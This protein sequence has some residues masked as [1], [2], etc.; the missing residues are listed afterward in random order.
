MFP[1]L[2]NI[3]YSFLLLSLFLFFCG[4]NHVLQSEDEAKLLANYMKLWVAIRRTATLEHI[5]SEDKLDMAP[6]TEDRT[7]PLLGKV[8]LPP[9]MIQ[10]LDIILTLGV[11]LPLQKQV[12]EDM[13]KLVM[14]N[15]PRTWMTMYLITFMSLQSCA[16]LTAENYRNARRQGF[17]VS[18][19]P[20]LGS[21]FFISVSLFVSFY[22]SFDLS[23]RQ[24][25]LRA[26]LDMTSD[27]SHSRPSFK[28]GT[29][30]PTCS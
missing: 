4:S 23:P 5:I 6:E 29:M 2:T 7:Y 10:Q 13:Q 3:A 25:P 21:S 15:N 28:N 11:L 8:P 22:H 17:R 30:P 19:R 18:L 26:N 24:M 16:S 20:V 27:A 12:L 9:V 1:I 14:S